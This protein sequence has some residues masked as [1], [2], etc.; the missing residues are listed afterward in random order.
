MDFTEH[1][2]QSHDG[3]SL[4]YRNYGS[5]KDTVIC[6]PG[7]TRNSKDF[8]EIATHLAS[9]YRVLC[10][11]LRGRGQSAWDPEW[12]HYVPGTYVDDTWKMVDQL[13]IDDFIIIGTSLGGLIAIIMASQLPDRVKAIILNDIGPEVNPAGYARVLAAAG[14][15]FEAKDWPEAVR[16]CREANE[17]ILTDMPEGFWDTFTRKTY[18]EGADG[19]RRR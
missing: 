13:G 5:G 18:R 4:Y 11:D 7:L 1:R 19:N 6:L 3:L 12:R 16:Y 17:S 9:K 14:S 10:P 2:F 15:Q 8:H